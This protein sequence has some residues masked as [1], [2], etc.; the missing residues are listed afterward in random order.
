MEQNEI[1][2]MGKMMEV[3]NDQDQTFEQFSV[4]SGDAVKIHTQGQSNIVPNL[5]ISK[6]T[7]TF[8]DLPELSLGARHHEPWVFPMHY[9][10]QLS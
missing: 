6:V 3:F 7:V 8:Q 5:I 1:D 2:G 9:L 10:T 4:N